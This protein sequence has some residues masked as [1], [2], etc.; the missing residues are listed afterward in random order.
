MANEEPPDEKERELEK[1][2]QKHSKK[3]KESKFMN[4]QEEEA[5][6]VNL[7]KIGST[8]TLN[9]SNL[10]LSKV[11]GFL[12]KAENMYDLQEKMMK[13]ASNFFLLNKSS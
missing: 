5:Y 4:E 7:Y 10:Q 2:F 1:I 8:G 3:T 9:A 12:D 11:R 6:V 13:E